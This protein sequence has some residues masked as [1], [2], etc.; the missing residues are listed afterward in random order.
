ML[1]NEQNVAYQII[2]GWYPYYSFDIIDKPSIIYNINSI[3]F[4]PEAATNIGEKLNFSNINK[5]TTT[6]IITTKISPN[7]MVHINVYLNKLIQL[8]HYH[9][10]TQFNSNLVDSSKFPHSNTCSTIDSK[11]CYINNSEKIGEQPHFTEDTNTSGTTTN[12]HNTDD[13]IH[14]NI[15][16]TTNYPSSPR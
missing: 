5:T 15:T 2:A 3:N 12:K 6:K 10:S 8:L 11:I 16:T 7:Q 1:Y 14:S 13:D 9:T 4:I